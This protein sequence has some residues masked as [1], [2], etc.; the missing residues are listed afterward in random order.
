[1]SFEDYMEGIQKL[2]GIVQELENLCIQMS[3]MTDIKNLNKMFNNDCD[4][5]FSEAKYAIKQIEKNDYTNVEYTGYA[6]GFNGNDDERI[7]EYQKRCKIL[8]V[9]VAKLTARYQE[10]KNLCVKTH[11]DTLQKLILGAQFVYITSD[12]ERLK[13]VVEKLQAEA[14][15]KESETKQQAKIK[16]AEIKQHEATVATQNAKKEEAKLAIETQKTEQKRLDAEERKAKEEQDILPLEERFRIM[17]NEFVN[18]IQ[19]NVAGSIR[20]KQ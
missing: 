5:L 9:E 3:Q 14:S 1:M 13:L 6:R 18:T 12:N 15:I 2:L 19:G 8:N 16:E 11:A 4:N 20:Q 7:S 10:Y 17:F